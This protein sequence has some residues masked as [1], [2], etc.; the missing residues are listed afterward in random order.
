MNEAKLYIETAEQAAQL[1]GVI[2]EHERKLAALTMKQR[3]A[4]AQA[5]AKH[6]AAITR[7]QQFIDVLRGQ[8]ESACT[9]LR[10][11]GLLKKTNAW[12]TGTVSFKQTRRIDI[13]DPSQTIA[14]LER[15][16]DLGRAALKK[17]IKVVKA[18]LSSWC[19]A[20]LTRIGATRISGES[21]CIKP[22]NG[23][24]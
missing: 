1:L 23:G 16:G 19:N 5:S 6:Q 8:L 7:E 22:A 21:V 20:D 9:R 17:D 11:E 12:P 24:T 15:M 4:I 3:A 14:T 10:T 18:V 13:P 2:G